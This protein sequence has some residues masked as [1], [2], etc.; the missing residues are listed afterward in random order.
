MGKIKYGLILG[1]VSVFGLIGATTLSVNINEKQ[2]N[3]LTNSPSL[4]S[5]NPPSVSFTFNNNSACSGTVI[6]FTS[7]VTGTGP[8]T[9]N[10]DFGDGTSSTNANPNK[11]FNAFGCGFSNFTVTL[12][13][14]DESDNSTASSSQTVTVE[15]RPQLIFEDLDD[16]FLPFDN[17]GNNTVDPTYIINVGNVSPSAGCI[18]SYDVSWG[19]GTSDTNITFPITHTYTVIQEVM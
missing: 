6:N 19:D 2:F 5:I 15:Q 8:F 12:T 9:Y 17:C 16:Q 10:W 4:L 7:T 13:V 18:T 14:T 11:V 1:I 3:L